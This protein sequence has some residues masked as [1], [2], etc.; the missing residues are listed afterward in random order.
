M[1]VVHQLEVLGGGCRGD[2]G[3]ERG[4]VAENFPISAVYF[5]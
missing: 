3:E 5:G 1:G 2:D 4:G